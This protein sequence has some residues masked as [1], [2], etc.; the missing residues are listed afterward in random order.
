MNDLYSLIPSLSWGVDVKPL[1]QV[2]EPA[3]IP[4]TFGKYFPTFNYYLLFL[5]N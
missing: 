5:I 1:P 3:P 4:K 2:G